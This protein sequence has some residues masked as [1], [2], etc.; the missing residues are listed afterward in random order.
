MKLIHGKIKRGLA[1]IPQ[2]MMTAHRLQFLCDFWGIK[3]NRKNFKTHYFNILRV[4][5]TFKTFHKMNDVMST[6]RL[7]NLDMPLPSIKKVKIP[8][9]DRISVTKHMPIGNGKL[10]A[11]K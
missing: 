11:V 9:L 4:L 2:Q 1:V 8:Y 5:I 6:P 3:C 7:R 10:K